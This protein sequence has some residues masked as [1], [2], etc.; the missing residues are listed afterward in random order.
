MRSSGSLN[1]PSSL[2]SRPQDRTLESTI[3]RS[4]SWR[5]PDGV[6]KALG[7]LY[8]DWASTS[9]AGAMATAHMHIRARARVRVR[10]RT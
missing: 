3:V 4:K 1:Q 9:A 8:I 10:A 6:P 7:G 2:C 5:A